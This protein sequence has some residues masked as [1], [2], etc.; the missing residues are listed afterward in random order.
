ME[1]ELISPS[2]PPTRPFSDT[3]QFNVM[4]VAVGVFNPLIDVS[5]TVIRGAPW[6]TT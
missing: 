5:S 3:P 4:R 6:P 1:I 2:M